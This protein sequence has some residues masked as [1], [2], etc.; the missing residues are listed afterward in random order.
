[1]L[2]WLAAAHRR[3][4]GSVPIR[5]GAPRIFMALF[6]ESSPADV[7]VRPFVLGARLAVGGMVAIGIARPVTPAARLPRADIAA[8]TFD[9][10]GQ[11][12][13]GRTR[14]LAP[15]RHEPL[16]KTDVTLRLT[17]AEWEGEDPQ[18]WRRR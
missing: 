11:A 18:D 16:S 15:I 2:V 3:G 6:E 4:V 17:G 12:A 14:T 7:R 1:V 8:A 9:E 13:I 10:V 5:M